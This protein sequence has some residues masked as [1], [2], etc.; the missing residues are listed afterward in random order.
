MPVQMG[1]VKSTKSSEAQLEQNH[2]HFLLVGRHL[3][4][5]RLHLCIRPNNA[6]DDPRLM[7]AGIA[8]LVPR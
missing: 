8:I 5:L 4:I 2:S 1:E 3:Q 7:M 6:A